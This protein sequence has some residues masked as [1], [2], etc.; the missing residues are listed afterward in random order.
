MDTIENNDNLSLALS[1]LYLFSSRW[2]G[3]GER[4]EYEREKVKLNKQ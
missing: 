2:Y 4:E 1:S 3:K